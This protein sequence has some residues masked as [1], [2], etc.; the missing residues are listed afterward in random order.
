MAEYFSEADP[1]EDPVWTGPDVDPE[2]PGKSPDGDDPDW[3]KLPM[4][5]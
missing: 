2:E 3:D 1:S 5:K 4:P